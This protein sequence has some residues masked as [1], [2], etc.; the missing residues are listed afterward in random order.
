MCGPR[1]NPRVV[2]MGFVVDKVVL[3]RFITENFHL[4]LPFIVSLVLYTYLDRAEIAQ[5]T[6]G[7]Q[8]GRPGFDSWQGNNI[9][10]FIASRPA[11][12]PIQPSLLG[13]LFLGV[14]L[15]ESQKSGS[16]RG[17]HC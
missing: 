11:L 1:F 15:A 6:S 8:A 12:G 5:Y 17:G 7:L 10:V 16:R 9:L 13:A 2:C 3:G 4:R 14:K